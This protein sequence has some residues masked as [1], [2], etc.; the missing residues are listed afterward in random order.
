[1]SYIT[2]E[3]KPIGLFAQAHAR[4][5]DPPA[6]KRAAERIALKADTQCGK[7][8]AI[9]R[10]GPIDNGRLY[11]I[12]A[13]HGILNVRARVSD[14]RGWGCVVEVDDAGVYRLVKDVET[15]GAA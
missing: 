7:L 12:A 11:Q 2:P 6:S 5:D 4:R 9:L 15:E 1:M 8:L 13:S 3:P 10:E 14:L